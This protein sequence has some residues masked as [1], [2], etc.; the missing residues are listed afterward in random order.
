MGTHC[1]MGIIDHYDKSIVGTYVHYDG[2]PDNMIPAIQGYVREKTLTGLHVLITQSQSG[3]GLH[4]FHQSSKG[5]LQSKFL[6]SGELC[7]IN[8]LNFLDPLISFAYLVHRHTGLLETFQ[9]TTGKNDGWKKMT[10]HE[11][12]VAM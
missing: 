1:H 4:C 11:T 6:D 3:G 9:R 12:Y 7:I 10:E 5:M 2:Y 8:E